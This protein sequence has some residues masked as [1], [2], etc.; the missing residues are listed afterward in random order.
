VAA[1]GEAGRPV[2]MMSRARMRIDGG[3]QQL[4]ER[5]RVDAHD[6]LQLS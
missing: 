1:P 5:G 2:A 6:T 3:V 4:V